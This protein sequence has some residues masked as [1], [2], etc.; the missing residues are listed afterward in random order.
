MDV[1]L[2]DTFIIALSQNHYYL[3]YWTEMMQ[4]NATSHI[5]MLFK[6]SIINKDMFIYNIILFIYTISID[7][8]VQFK[9]VFMRVNSYYI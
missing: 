7:T 9:S 2:G 4:I 5:Q 3:K 8:H 1:S 6:S